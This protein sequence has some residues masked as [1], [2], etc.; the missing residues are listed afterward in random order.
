MSDTLN[1]TADFSLNADANPTR[2]WYWSIHR[3]LWENRSLT[4]APVAVATAFLFATFFY[5]MRLSDKMRALSL[6]EWADKRTLV[7]PYN[8]IAGSL[9]ITAFIIGAFY[10]LDALSGERRD[11]SILFWKSL[12]VSDRTTVLS[13]AAI[14]L[15]VL[16]AFTFAIVIASHLVILTQTTAALL[17]SDHGPAPLWRNLPL[18][19]TW[20]AVLYG[21]IAITLW[22]A[23]IYAW[24]LFVSGWAR[25]AALLWA[26]LPFVVVSIAEK[27]AFATTYF[28]DF[29]KHRMWGWFPKAY[30]VQ[31]EGTPAD[32]L[33][34]LTPEQFFTTPG[35]WI[36]LAFA[37]ALLA[38]TVRMRRDR[39]PV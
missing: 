33:T 32:P 1:P 22:H 18:L 11:R 19:Q 36:G 20:I 29:L 34:A 21:I 5:V 37:A 6:A 8:A 3:E 39:E 23:P 16:P 35:L 25:R 24:F 10:C 4:I 9:V 38:A 26:I 15:I 30:F 31:A 12:P 17:G 27:I 7:A 28:E 13:K 2:P 14:P